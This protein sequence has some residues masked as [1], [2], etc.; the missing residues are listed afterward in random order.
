MKK[1]IF[2]FLLMLCSMSYSEE[3]RYTK[4][5]IPIRFIGLMDIDNLNYDNSNI[6][7]D[8]VIYKIIQ[9]E[10]QLIKDLAYISP[11]R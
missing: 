3:L 6:D 7:K 10:K 2:I 5:G 1:I 9:K 11:S 8:S 4:S